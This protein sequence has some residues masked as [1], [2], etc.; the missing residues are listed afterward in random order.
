MRPSDNPFGQRRQ[1]MFLTDYVG[2]SLGTPF[3]RKYL[4]AHVDSIT[5]VV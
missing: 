5:G 1:H 3:S 4:I 2:E